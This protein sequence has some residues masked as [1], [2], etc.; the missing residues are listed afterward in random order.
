MARPKFVHE[1][2]GDLIAAKTFT[3]SF[4]SVTDGGI[5]T[6][7]TSTTV[8]TVQTWILNEVCDFHH[9]QPGRTVT[10]DGNS[11]VI[12]DYD[13][14][15]KTLTV[16]GADPIS[17]TSFNLY[18][19]IFTHGTPMAKQAELSGA[20]I[21][22]IT[23]LI[24]LMEPY[25]PVEDS[26]PRSNIEYKASVVLCFLTEAE[27]SQETDDLY[28]MGITPMKNLMEDVVELIK[29]SPA[30]YSREMTVKPRYHTKFEVRMREPGP[31]AVYFDKH[32]SGVSIDIELQVYKDYACDC[33]EAVIADDTDDCVHEL[34]DS[35]AF[36]IDDLGSALWTEDVNE[37]K[38]NYEGSSDEPIR[39]IFTDIE[40]GWH[41]FEISFNQVTNTL[42]IEGFV[43][44][45]TILTSAAGDHKIMFYYSEGIDNNYITLTPHD[46][47][48]LAEFPIASVQLR[49]LL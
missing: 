23:P 46:A 9:A 24:L 5:I 34:G 45:E 48:A 39:I 41:L 27:L 43:A 38:W 3:V 18:A 2:L 1:L 35:V 28:Y 47:N 6:Y 25:E 14:D 21:K 15:E 36:T 8:G 32:Y 42:T 20:T 10:I 19:P 33:P 49:K 17:V 40:T 13:I 12:Q 11:Y 31:K 30:F 44:G 16:T 29:K 7:N 37:T 4:D 26:N 22:E